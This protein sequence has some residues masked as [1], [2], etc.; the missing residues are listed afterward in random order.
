MIKTKQRFSQYT[1][2]KSKFAVRI[3]T[4]YNDYMRKHELGVVS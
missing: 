4:D 1:I 2:T 3:S